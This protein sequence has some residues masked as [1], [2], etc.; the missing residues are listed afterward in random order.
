M[1]Y[2]YFLSLTSL[3][4]AFLLIYYE[5]S[6]GYYILIAFLWGLLI[7][8]CVISVMMFVKACRRQARK[9]DDS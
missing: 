5:Y 2:L 4:T 9:E 6:L 8:E 1:K 7:L 3:F